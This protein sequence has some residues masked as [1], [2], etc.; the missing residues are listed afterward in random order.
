MAYPETVK[1][2][3]LGIQHGLS[4]DG[5]ALLFRDTAW[6]IQGG[7]SLLCRYIQNVLSRED[8]AS[9]FRDTA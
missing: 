1:R 6:L 2:C 5:E 8:T 4:R 7:C 9:L 3:C